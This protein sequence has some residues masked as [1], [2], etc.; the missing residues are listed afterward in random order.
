[1]RN[2][3]ASD[4]AEK[5]DRLTKQLEE[6]ADKP[7][8]DF[9]D[10]EKSDIATY[11]ND[12]DYTIAEFI[13]NRIRSG[14]TSRLA[15]NYV[16][17]PFNY[18]NGFMSEHATNYRVSCDTRINLELAITKYAGKK[19]LEIAM[20][21]LTNNAR[22][23]VKG[24][25]YLIHHWILRTPAGTDRIE[26]LLNALG[27][28]D[29]QVSV[30]TGNNEDS[31]VVLRK[32]QTGKVNYSH[33][34]PAFGSL[35]EEE[36]FRVLCLYGR[37]DCNRLMDMFRTINTAAKH[38]I[39][40]LDYALNQD[41]RRKL[42][43][44]IKEEKSFAKCFIVVDRVVLLYLAKHYA[45][46]TVNR[47]LMAVTMPFA[48]YQPFVENSSQTMPPELFTGRE[49]ELTKIESADGA[50]LVYGGRQLGKSALL[51]MAQHNIDK[52]SNGDR[53]VL[54]EIKDLDY[55]AAAKVVS[56][57]LIVVGILD[58]SCR[59]DDWDISRW[60]P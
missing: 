31:Y 41:E 37:F 55:T 23:D 11:I 57:K 52:N 33:P 40:F 59:C 60:T 1:M 24:G 44:K 36:G 20:K 2:K 9:G 56:N 43:R 21:H 46:N 32:K 51:K 4:A 50:N 12:Q 54:L 58:E 10:Y 42:A 6:L 8:Y 16:D 7:E 28:T 19:N 13:L 14:D 5:G 22:K 3:I 49:D 45:T 30:D 25:C 27:F 47:M 17:E 48:Y 34:I 35:A 53:A 39:V 18:F 38:T 29:C 26:R 15:M